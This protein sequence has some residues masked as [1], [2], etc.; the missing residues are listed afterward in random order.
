MKWFS[1]AARQVALRKY[2]YPFKAALAISND[3]DGMS[4]AA[5]KDWRDFVNGSGETEY[6][7]GLGL[8]VGDSF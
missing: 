6:G 4:W 1:G 5:F 8:E 3:A 7:T 2:P